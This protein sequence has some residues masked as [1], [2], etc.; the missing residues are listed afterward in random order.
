MPEPDD[1]Q[2]NTNVVRL[3]TKGAVQQIA[4]QPSRTSSA[5]LHD[6]VTPKSLLQMTDLELQQFIIQLRERRMKASRAL[7][8]AT[9][10]RQHTSLISQRDKM[11]RKITAAEKSLAAVDVALERFEK[12][13]TDLRAMQLNYTNVPLT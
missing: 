11:E 3:K 8:Q 5:E 4:A 1:R 9:D 13:V 12:L 7:K 2:K 6:A 10:A